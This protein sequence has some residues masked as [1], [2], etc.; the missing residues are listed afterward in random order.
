MAVTHAGQASPLTLS[1][2]ITR[3][4]LLLAAQRLDEA[5]PV[6]DALE[7]VPEMPAPLQL[8]IALAR[9][10]HHRDTGAIEAAQA[11]LPS[12]RELADGL[13]AQALPL[14]AQIEALEA[15]LR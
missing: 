3:A 6:L 12:V 4:E 5:A 14:R 10:N 11:A 9:V 13:G 7:S 1:L 2:R 15:S 8:R